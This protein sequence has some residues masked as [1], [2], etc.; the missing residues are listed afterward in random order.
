VSNS[1]EEKKQ[2]LAKIANL[3]YIRS[4]AMVPSMKGIPEMSGS[5]EA[6]PPA[7]VPDRVVVSG[8]HLGESV[9]ARIVARETRR[10]GL[11]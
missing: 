7:A 1:A 8:A 2:F 4:Y 6:V 11:Q 10:N 9:I 3:F 5:V